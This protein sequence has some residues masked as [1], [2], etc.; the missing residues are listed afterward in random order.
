V[1][2]RRG[3][4]DII[5][6][7]RVTVNGKVIKEPGFR[8]TPEDEIRLDRGLLK[9]KKKHIYLVLHKPTKYLCSNTDPSGRSLAIDLIKPVISDRLFNVGRL[10]YLTS[11]LLIFTNDGSF[12]E[13]MLHPRFNVEK[14]YL[15]VTKKEIPEELME[16]FKQGITI[17]GVRYKAKDYYMRGPRQVSL[18]LEEGKNREIRN[19]FLSRNIFVKRVHRVRM[20]QLQIK[21]LAPGQFRHLKSSEVQMLLDIAEGKK[22][23][24]GF[25]KKTRKE[26]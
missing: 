1:A 17:E 19:V 2:S 24:P 12:N 16:Q 15:V 7:G 9:L 26:Q 3:A 23:N 25:V 8:V 11:G 10:D 14:E 6:A 20:G 18:I 21:G 13:K 5:N 4:V 22:K